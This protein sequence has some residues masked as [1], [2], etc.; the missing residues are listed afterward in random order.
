MNGHKEYLLAQA[1]ESLLTRGGTQPQPV[2]SLFISGMVFGIE[3]PEMCQTI[4][5]IIT[6]EMSGMRVS[7]FVGKYDLLRVLRIVQEHRGYSPQVEAI[8]ENIAGELTDADTDAVDEFNK[9]GE[10][11]Q[12]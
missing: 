7:P 1:L 8:L 4:L 2:Y 10:D 11:G 6:S 12:T 9:G 3:N 5:G